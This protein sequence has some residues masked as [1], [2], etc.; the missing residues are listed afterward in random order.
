[1]IFQ[2]SI[3]IFPEKWGSGLFVDRFETLDASAGCVL[4]REV[5]LELHI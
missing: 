4:V 3:S 1:M 2:P 5:K